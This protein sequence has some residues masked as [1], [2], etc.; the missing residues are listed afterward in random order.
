MFVALCAA[1]VPAL[2]ALSRMDAIAAGSSGMRLM[3]AGAMSAAY[4]AAANS[5]TTK[6]TIAPRPTRPIDFASGAL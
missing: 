5:V 3:N 6:K 2:D 1:W 4:A